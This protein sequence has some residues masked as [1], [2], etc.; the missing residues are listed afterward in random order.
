[1]LA[2]R[3]DLHSFVTLLP[4]KGQTTSRD[5][6]F[7]ACRPEFLTCLVKVLDSKGTS[8]ASDVYSFGV[9]VWEVF[10]RK[11]PWAD[12]RCHRDIFVR[13]VFKED[14]PEIP[15]ESPVDMARIMK[16]SWARVPQDRPTFSDIMKWQSWE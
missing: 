15:V 2:D 4:R 8:Y 14:R 10:S 13:V 6:P 9:V 5:V 16:A 7:S 12:E 11:L 3:V 1:M